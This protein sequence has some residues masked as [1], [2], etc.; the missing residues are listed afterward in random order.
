MV[1]NE[2]NSQINS[3][4]RGMNSDTSYDQIENQQYVFGQNIRITKNQLLGGS[5][6][7]S[8]LHEGIVT[9]VVQGAGIVDILSNKPSFYNKK[10]LS[11]KTVDNLGTIVCNTKGSNDI[12]VYR[13]IIDEVENELKE[14]RLIW[15]SN[16]EGWNADDIPDQ[17]STVLYKELDNVIKLYIAT[18]AHPIISIR[19]DDEGIGKIEEGTT[20]DDFISNR[21]VPT[22]RICIEGITSGRLTTSQVQYTY[23]YYNKYGNTTQLAPLTNKIQVIDSSRSKEIGNAEDTE[24]SIGFILSIDVEKYLGHYERLQVYRLQYIKPGEDANVALI[25]DGEIKKPQD[26]KTFT[27]NDIGIDP[28]QELTIEEFSAM[29]GI[30]LIPKTIEQNQEY[31]FCANV[32]DDTIIRN[33][34]I[35]DS[36]YNDKDRISIAKA[37]VVLSEKISGDIPDPG[38]NKYTSQYNT[39]EHTKASSNVTNT[40][41]DYLKQR[42]INPQDVTASYNNIITSSLLRSLRRGETYKYAIV[43]YDKYGRRTDVASI[44]E[45]ETPDYDES[46]PF[47]CDDKLLAHPIGVDIKIPQISNPENIIGC[48]IVRRSSSDVY[49]KTLLQVALARPVRQ[50]I[51]DLNL[52][53]EQWDTTTEETIKKSPFYP[54][55]FMQVNDMI[56]KPSYYYDAYLHPESSEDLIYWIPVTA[57]YALH[58][59][60]KG[61][62]LYQIFSQEIDFRRDDVLSR[63]NVSDADIVE[64]LYIPSNFAKYSNNTKD[65]LYENTLFDGA[66]VEDSEQYSKNKVERYSATAEDSNTFWIEN[67]IDTSADAVY[68]NTDPIVD[69]YEAKFVIMGSLDES[70]TFQLGQNILNNSEIVSFIN[71][72]ASYNYGIHIYSAQKQIKYVTVSTATG[73]ETIIEHNNSNITIDRSKLNKLTISQKQSI[74]YIFNF[75]KTGFQEHSNFGNHEVNSIKDVKM[76]GWNDGFTSVNRDADQ[77]VFDAIKKY[78][79][80]TT[81]IDSYIYDNWVSFGKYDFRPGVAS[82]PNINLGD[83]GSLEV[84]ELL[85]KS[86]S[87]VYW[88]ETN[89]YDMNIRKGPIGPGPSCFLL[90]TKDDAA[91]FPMYEDKF[92]TSICNIQ[93]TPKTADIKSEE[94]EQYFGFGNYF[95]L[96]INNG[97]LVTEDNKD[98]LTVFDGDIYITPHEFTTMYKTYNFESVDTI[99]STQITNYIPL[100]SKVNTFFDYGMN[101][102]NTQSENL[103][104]EPGSIDGVTTQERPV[105]Q[106]NMIYSDNDSSNDVFTLISTDENE[107]NNFKQRAYY[108]ELKSNGEFID[109]FLVFKAAAFID[110]D[111]K[112]GQITNMLTDKNMLYYWQDHAFGKFSVN[113]RSLVNDQNNNTIMLG[114]A[115]ILS[116]YDYLSTKYGMRLYDFCA[117]SVENGIYWVDINN[118]AVVGTN[119]NQVANYGEQVG[120]QN[121]INDRITTDVPKVDYD[122]QNNELLCKCFGDDQIVFNLKYNIA[123][124]IYTRRYNNIAYIKNH[125]YGLFISGD[126]LQITKHNYLQYEDM[127]YLTPLQ[128]EFIVNPAASITKVYDSQQLIPIKRDRFDTDEH[129]LDNT[130][131]AFETDLV[132]KQYGESMEPY[133]D[134]EGNIIYNIPRYQNMPYGN[135]I[136]GKWMK[137]NINNN[138]PSEYFTIS[139]M[140]TKFRQSFS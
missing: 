95:N 42:G 62:Q 131:F 106:Y 112:Y 75:F 118:K 20:I 89:R 110:V 138:N 37:T 2:N 72:H 5:G 124:S 57:Q 115:G 15:S 128:L 132:N 121:I 4:G 30:I 25:Y 97:K 99:Q 67:K 137:V 44:G 81:N 126:N 47:T 39:I 23:R 32:K 130:T 104:Y 119:G 46:R 69:Q 93:H 65:E 117:I 8:S 53:A 79:S 88:L 18:G 35:P 103:L 107:T 84:Q 36:Y 26:G 96:K 135:R 78:R 60:T 12:N 43:F 11:V 74:H 76:A 85:G 111:S 66:T 52:T 64:K 109:N 108:S 50:G 33:S 10:I 82:A 127:D 40:V 70:S 41:T 17:V 114:Q 38:S 102:M 80:Y 125:I 116:R 77:N 63:L 136:R 56:I 9:P 90:T 98:Y 14:L 22:D 7:Y 92:Y 71:N 68:I 34:K 3:F 139:H 123:T 1:I 91:V 94:Y 86:D 73:D 24:T 100:E 48:Q 21:I 61:Q 16:V 29:S 54:S 122:L 49:Q 120:V 59:K 129:I 101:L 140:I 83:N 27:L 87:Y 113:E 51:L 19:V 28:I 58:A 55:G 134:R 6:D 13:F 45:I 133:T 105:H 31:M